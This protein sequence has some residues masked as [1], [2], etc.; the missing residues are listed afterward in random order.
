MN[1][2]WKTVLYAQ[3]NELLKCQSIPYMYGQKW[4]RAG[5]SNVLAGIITF[6]DKS[7]MLGCV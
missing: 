3:Q 5:I 1:V 4:L 6:P 2:V 7:I